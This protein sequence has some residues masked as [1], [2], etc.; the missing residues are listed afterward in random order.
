MLVCCAIAMDVDGCGSMIIKVRWFKA[1]IV[2]KEA[3]GGAR[4]IRKG[5]GCGRSKNAQCI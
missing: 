5:E 4:A 2:I 3:V 1:M